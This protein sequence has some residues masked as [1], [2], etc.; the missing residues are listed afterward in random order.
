MFSPAQAW[1]RRNMTG[2]N[3]KR[4]WVP[5]FVMGVTAAAV[6]AAPIAAAE[7][8]PPPTITETV[9]PPPPPPL[10]IGPGGSGCVE[11][12]GCGSGNNLGGGGCI[13]GVGCGGGGLPGAPIP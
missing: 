2:T 6:A 5:V 1:Y 3:L 4:K 10:P 12:V 13:P 11:G 9:A 7:P 8:P